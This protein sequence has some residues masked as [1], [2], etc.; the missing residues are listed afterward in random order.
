MSGG[1]ASKRKGSAAERQLC[2]LLGDK[3]G[4]TFIRSNNSG[5][6]VGGKNFHR[7]SGL[8][9]AQLAG[10]RGDIVPPEHLPRLVVESKSYADFPYALMT[11]APVALLDK[12]LEQTLEAAEADDFW[13]LAFKTNRRPW[14]VAFDAAHAPVMPLERYTRY[15]SSS[16]LAVHV[17]ALDLFLSSSAIVIKNLSGPK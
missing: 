7:K 9:D 5:A 11:S 8:S 12:W 2:Q 3:L 10:V 13:L 6:F 17:A 14:M 1:S 16:G 4:G 15:V